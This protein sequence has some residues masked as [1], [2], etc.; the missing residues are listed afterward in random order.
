[1]K[2]ERCLLLL[3]I[4]LLSQTQISFIGSIGISELLI[5]LV[6]PLVFFLDYN[7]LRADG[8]LPFVWLSILC[9]LTCILS[10]YINHTPLMFIIKGLAHPYSLFA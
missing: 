4:G 1:M 6:A 8:F 7:R 9:C 10:S 3:L 2:R 5:F